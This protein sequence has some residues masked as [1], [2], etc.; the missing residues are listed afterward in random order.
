MEIVLRENWLTRKLEGSAAD[1]S[2]LVTLTLVLGCAI[3]WSGLFGWHAWMSATGEQVFVQHQWWRAWTTLF[4]HGD[5][6]H[7][8]SNVFMFYVLGIFLFG[9]FGGFVF[10]LL[11]F[12]SGG[13]I[14]LIV[15][16][17][18][19]N[20]IALIGASGVV[21]WM[22]GFWLTL[23]FLIDGRRTLMARAV[24]ALG[25]A[26]GVF[27]PTE[28]F[29]PGVSYMSH[30][31]GFLLGIGLALLYYFFRRRE[32]AAAEVREL[33][34]DEEEPMPLDPATFAEDGSWY[35]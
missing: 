20:D 7:L 18:M 19:P 4:V 29:D 16:H 26:L 21:Y 23:Y 22:A 35:N 24:R 25:V 31:W 28:T 34:P 17:G 32:F 12:V 33:V 1:G 30:L 3:S 10:P 8:L 6:R 27:M 2:A 11:A 15:L 14:N 13:F 9:Y 5:L